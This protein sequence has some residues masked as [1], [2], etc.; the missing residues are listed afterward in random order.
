MTSRILVADNLPKVLDT[1]ARILESQGHEVVRASSPEEVRREFAK[2]KFDL[3]VLDVRLVDEDDPQDES[4]LL[5]AEEISPSTPVILLTG[6][7]NEDLILAAL[8]P[9]NS[10]PPLAANFVRKKDGPAKLIV[11]VQKALVPRVFVVHGHNDGARLAVKELIERLGLKPVILQEEPGVG[12]SIL[13]KI[14]AYSDV[15]FVVVLLTP[16]DVGG[17][18]GSSSFRPR[19]RQNVIFELGFFVGRLNSRRVAALYREEDEALEIPT[20]YMGIQY[21]SMDSEGGWERKLAREIAAT[22]I[23]VSFDRLLL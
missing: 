6:K 9:R 20:D 22:G 3:V 18:R 10:G 17:A 7:S 14:E 1:T 16:D 19:A 11:A 15:N 2:K 5:I 8:R 12:Q 23:P 21:I 13:Q 4:G